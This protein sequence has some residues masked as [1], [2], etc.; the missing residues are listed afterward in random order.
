MCRPQ[1]ASWAGFRPRQACYLGH[2]RRRGVWLAVGPGPVGASLLPAP[3]PSLHDV[4]ACQEAGPAVQ[5]AALRLLPDA[6]GYCRGEP[7]VLSLLCTA[8][9]P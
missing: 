1:L 8:S 3:G 9:A 7:L 5:E 2:P 4:L 6:R